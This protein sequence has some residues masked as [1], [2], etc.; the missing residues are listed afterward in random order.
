M[1]RPFFFAW[2]YN[3]GLQQVLEIWKNFLFFSWRYFSVAELLLT[4]FAPWHR[5]VEIRNWR[6]WNPLRSS[7]MLIENFFSRLIGLIVRLVVISIGLIFFV[8]VFAVGLGAVLLWICGPFLVIFLL[9][10]IL[11]G[12][13]NLIAIVPLLAWIAFTLFCYEYDTATPLLEMIGA[14]FIKH[15]MFERIC[16]RLGLVGKNFPGEIL[17][18]QAMLTEFLKIRGITLAEYQQIK[19]WEL[20]RMQ[21]QKAEKEFWTWENLKRVIPIGMQWR[22]GYTVHLDRY[23]HDLSEVDASEY[24]K[25]ELI[26]RSSEREILKLILTRPDQN[27]ALL[28][29]NAGIGR[30][31]LIHGL[32]REIRTGQA[33]DL[34]QNA[35][36]MLLDLGRVIS[37]AINRG[38]DVENQLRVVFHEAAW[39]GNII[40]VIEHIEHY[41]GGEGNL[42][43]PDVSAVLVDFLAMP[44]FHLI[45][46]STPGEYH[47]LIEKKQQLV[48][49]FEIIEVTQPSEI[50]AIEIMQQQ[51]EK[52]EQKKVLFTYGALREIV[53]SSSKHNWSV[54]LPERALDLMMDTLMFW[55]KEPTEQFVTE[56]TVDAYLSFKTGIKQGSIDNSE[57]KKLL[58]LENTLHRQVVGQEQAVSQVAEALRRARSGIGD[59]EK[60]IGSFLF[61]GPTGVGKTE[62]AKAL[63]KVYFGDEKHVIRLDMSEFQTPN[64]IDRL[65]GSSQLNKQ[66]RLVTQI[67]D[68]PYSLLLLDEIEKAYPDILDIFLQILD[69]GFVT[70]AFGEKI[71]FR[72]CMIIAT[73]NAGAALIK[74]MV[75]GQEKAEQIKQAVID[76]TV[77][78]NIF[79]VEFLNRFSGVIFFR[80]LNQKELIDVVWLKLQNFANRLDKEKNIQ[81]DFEENI[82]EK[83]IEKGYNPIF[84]ARSLNRYIEDT[85]EN[86][87]AKKI[88]AGQ[89]SN[90]EKIKIEL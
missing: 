61:L 65:L 83:I 24:A 32:A 44:S 58:K 68:N 23:A 84:G 9:S 12:Q 6:G 63:A 88:I 41:L 59:N 71:N 35:R 1:K 5:D 10:L 78:N 34:F 56:K 70:D 90:G 66:G 11:R 48:K 4:L 20:V 85:V 82:A 39:A 46:T 64:S 30:K 33:Q 13:L 57:R 54:P 29:G 67:K 28:V 42:L 87:V 74:K 36:I 72:N 26:G 2:Y 17:E 62:T 43:H 19:Q 55:E 27:C 40:L 7:E 47:Q 80:P 81:I 73:S 53:S 77:K 79:K 89:A 15:S 52:Y 75:E 86:L 60:P 38:Q 14:E 16:N 8:A 21:Q 51:L 50:E 18:N 25:A 69:E 76:Y 37:D 3:K 49:Y 45:C 22:Y 31:T